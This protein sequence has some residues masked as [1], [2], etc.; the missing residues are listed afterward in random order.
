MKRTNFTL[1]FFKERVQIPGT[2]FS[3]SKGL[4]ILNN[5]PVE[6]RANPLNEFH[7]QQRTH[8]CKSFSDLTVPTDFHSTQRAH[9]PKEVLH[10][11]KDS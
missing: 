8:C 5:S 6:Q 7:I 11:T 10:Q 1:I 9:S 2:I 3:L 4:I